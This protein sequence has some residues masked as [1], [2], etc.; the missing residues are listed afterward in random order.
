VRAAAKFVP[1]REISNRRIT[2]SLAVAVTVAVSVFSGSD[3]LLAWMELPSITLETTINSP[4]L[5]PREGRVYISFGQVTQGHSSVYT[6][7]EYLNTGFYFGE[8]LSNGSITNVSKI[9]DIENGG[10][11]GQSLLL[12]SNNTWMIAFCNSTINGLNQMYSPLYL[13]ESLDGV[14]W[15]NPTIVYD[16]PTE[17]IR[18][19][20][21]ELDDESLFLLFRADASW[22]WTMRKGGQWSEALPTPFGVENRAQFIYE[23]AFIDSEGRVNVVWDEGSHDLQDLGLRYS[24]LLDSGWTETSKLTSNNI[25]INGEEPR[26]FYSSKRGGYFLSVGFPVATLYFSRDMLSWENLGY[27]D[28][29]PSLIE[30]GDGSL[31]SLVGWRGSEDVFFMTSVNGT[32]WSTKEVV[33]M[34]QDPSQLAS[35]Q[36]FQRYRF[37]YAAG[38]TAFVVALLILTKLSIVK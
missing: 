32:S 4:T 7:P 3:L 26:I 34:I 19:T 9:A 20:L 37:S 25:N 24:T 27:F 36:A 18:P 1:N 11:I 17:N 8:L 22:M 10:G 21:L 12:T 6:G 5:A 2:F 31:V 28:Y 33:R 13:I 30:L 23:S 35:G 15:G 16:K 29:A 14:T 38:I